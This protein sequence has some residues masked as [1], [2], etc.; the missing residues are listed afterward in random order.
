LTKREIIVKTRA[1]NGREE[2]NL[3]SRMAEACREEVLK[4]GEKEPSGTSRDGDKGIFK[5]KGSSKSL[6]K[7]FGEKVHG[8]KIITR[9]YRRIRG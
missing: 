6:Q 2:G 1:E 5:K 9:V 7:V 8:G 4:R 3:T